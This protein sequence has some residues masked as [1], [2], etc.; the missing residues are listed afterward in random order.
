M[1][2]VAEK[3]LVSFFLFD[4]H[5]LRTVLPYNKLAFFLACLG[6]GAKSQIVAFP[7]KAQ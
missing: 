1:M 3:L 2:Q 4:A 7:T 5:H 6:W